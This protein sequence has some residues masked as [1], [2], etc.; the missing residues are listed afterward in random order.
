M[1]KKTTEDVVK[2]VSKW[3]YKKIDPDTHWIPG[4]ASPNPAGRPK[5]AKNQKTLYREAMAVKIAAKVGPTTRLMAKG[6]LGYHQLAN[7]SAGGDLK[8]IAL[9]LQ[10][11]AKFDE[12]EA[13]APSTA[14]SASDMQTLE[15]YIALRNKFARP[16]TQGDPAGG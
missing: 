14:D 13:A 12:P 11:D 9:Q 5:G 8:A 10:L 6:E 4:A 2:A 16:A 1:H 15:Y 7:K 3:G